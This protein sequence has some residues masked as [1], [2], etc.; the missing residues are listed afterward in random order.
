MNSTFRARWLPSSEVI[1]QVLFTSEQQEKNKMA[2]VAIFSQIKLLYGPLV[3]QLVWYILKQLFT[4]V[5][6]KVMDIY[7]PLRGSAN[8]HHYSPPLRWIIVNYTNTVYDNLSRYVSYVSYTSLVFR[9]ESAYISVWSWPHKNY[10]QVARKTFSFKK[11]SENWEKHFIVVASS[12]TPP[13]HYTKKRD[14]CFTSEAFSSVR[15]ELCFKDLQKTHILPERKMLTLWWCA[16]RI[17]ILIIEINEWRSFLF[18]FL[19]EFKTHETLRGLEK[20]VHSPTSSSI[21][22]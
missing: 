1:S 18:F 15:W 5:S 14:H 2:F 8:I 16:K 3:I 19:A 21:L 22:G 9:N 12:T 13:V 10:S 7:L 6:V 20:A 17:Y 4:S 11:N